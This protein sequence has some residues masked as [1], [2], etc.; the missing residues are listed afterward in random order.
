MT[1]MSVERYQFRIVSANVAL[2]IGLLSAI[3][4]WMLGSNVAFVGIPIATLLGWCLAPKL[5]LSTGSKV[6]ASFAMAFGCTL[7]GAYG[8][9]LLWSGD[10]VESI[11][12]AAIGIVLFG[13]PCFIALN[14]PALIWAVSTGRLLDLMVTRAR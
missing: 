5:R 2:V 7:L 8:T 1:Q 3:A 12:L 4:V 6:L 9:A 14:I 10:L 13:I 11:A